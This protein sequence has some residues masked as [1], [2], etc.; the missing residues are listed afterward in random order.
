MINNFTFILV[1]I[2]IL[3]FLNTFGG[4]KYKSQTNKYNVILINHRNYQIVLIS[5]TNNVQNKIF[6]IYKN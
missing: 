6:K 3:I 1:I 4:E 2:L 5:N